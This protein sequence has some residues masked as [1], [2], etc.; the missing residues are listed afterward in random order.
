MHECLHSEDNIGTD[1]D[2]GL[3]IESFAMIKLHDV[4]YK[5]YKYI[6]FI[7]F[8]WSFLNLLL[9]ER[10]TSPVYERNCKYSRLAITPNKAAA[11]F[12]TQMYWKILMLYSLQETVVQ[13]TLSFAT[14]QSNRQCWN[15]TLRLTSAKWKMLRDRCSKR[16]WKWWH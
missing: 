9:F 7:S 6:I 14:L 12:M 4:N 13:C 16:E 1:E 15:L 10:C 5:L 8:L 11:L 3:R 2:P